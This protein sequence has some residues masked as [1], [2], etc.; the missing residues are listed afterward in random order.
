ME[1]RLL[2]PSYKNSKEFYDDFV[3]DKIKYKEEYFTNEIYQVDEIPDFPIYM[4]QGSQD[5]KDADFLEAFEVIY[6][7]CRNMDR[8]I[9][10]NGRFWHSLFAVNKRGY[11]VDKYPQVLDSE[12]KFKNIVVK[13]FDWENYI[14]KI[15]LAVQYIAEK[16]DQIG[17]IEIRKAERQRYYRLVIDNLDF[18]NYIIKY[19][20]FRNS[21]FVINILDIIDENNLSEI[22]KAKVDIGSGADRDDRCGRRVIFELNKSYPIVMFQM[23]EKD[24]LAEVFFEYLGYYHNVNKLETILDDEYANAGTHL[25]IGAISRNLFKKRKVKVG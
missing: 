5:E 9:I 19:E 3:D 17:D 18:F 7:S 2:D 24:E 8:E 10:L 20:I 23:L 13:N 15:I 14:Y 12:S 25:N 1:I 6:R 4:A 22:L 11:I 21:N 16:T